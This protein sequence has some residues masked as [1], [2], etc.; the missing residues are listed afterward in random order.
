MSK[1]IGIFG[2]LF[3]LKN[4]NLGAHFVDILIA[5]IFK[6]IHFLKWC[7]P[8]LQFSKFNDF[9]C[10]QMLIVSQKPFWFCIPPL[11]SPQLVLPYHVITVLFWLFWRSFGKAVLYW[12]QFGVI[13][14]LQA[15]T[16][17]SPNQFLALDF[18]AISY[19]KKILEWFEANEYILKQPMTLKTASYGRHPAHCVYLDIY[20]SQNIRLCKGDFE[21]KFQTILQAKGI[22]FLIWKF[23]F[24]ILIFLLVFAEFVK[25]TAF[26]TLLL[27][28]QRFDISKLWFLHQNVIQTC[29]LF[30]IAASVCKKQW[31]WQILQKIEGK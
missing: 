21:G 14:D 13:Q 16:T 1:I 30:G 12:Y 31:I 10:V 6:S 25:S 19:S 4:T 3:S 23:R 24:I 9:L 20:I 18:F 28:F 29:Q 8:L 15:S 11:T 22:N 5:S 7:P 26:Y 27:L 2:I 17:Y